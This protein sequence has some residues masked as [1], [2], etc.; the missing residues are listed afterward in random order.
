MFVRKTLKA[1]V[2]LAAYLLL[3]H[4]SIAFSQ[5]FTLE[6]ILSAPYVTNLTTAGEA[7]VLAWV[8]N[9]K[10]VRNIWVAAAPDFQPRQVT[11]YTEDDG[12]ALGSLRLTRDGRILVYVRGGSANRAGEHPNP[13]SDPDGAEQAI[14]AVRT[15]G[16]EPWRLAAGSRPL[17]SPDE[18]FV[19][20]LRKGK[21]F[22]VE[23][24]PPHG[25]TPEA[26][27]LFK[28]RGRVGHL[29]WS[30]D[31]QKLAFVSFR[32]DHNFVGIYE[33]QQHKIRWIAPGVDRDLR[34]V[35]S[36]DGRRL[37]FIR[38]PGAKKHEL[39]NIMSGNPFAIWVADAATG[40]AREIWRSPGDDGGFAQYY[41][42]EPLRWTKN[43]RILFYSEHEGWM[44]IYSMRPD[45]SD[46]QDLTPG[47]S[48]AEHSAVSPDG[49]YLYF[50]SNK[51]DIDRRHIWR[52][53]TEGG[54][55]EAVTRGQGIETDPVVLASGR[56]IAYRAAG[57]NHPP[58][59]TLAQAD[60]KKP[61]AVY[62]QQ[63]P[64]DF[65]QKELVVPQPVIFTSGDGWKI[66]AQLFL[67][68]GAKP[69]DNR[70]ALIFMHGGPI[71]QMLLGWHY[72]GYYANAYAMN[73]YMASKGYVVLSV[74]YR[75]GIG[76]GRDFRLAPN[77]GPRGASEYQDIIAAGLYLQKRPEVDPHKIGLWG[78]SYGGYLTAMGLARDSDLFAAGVDLH[79]VHD[80]AFRA[81]DFSP[82]GGWG[83]QGE[84]LLELALKSSPVAD[85][86]Y[87]TSPILLIHGDD[88]RNVLFQ[89]TTDLVQRL[90]EKGVHTEVLVFPDEVHGFLRYESWLRAYQATADFFD[91][92]LRRNQ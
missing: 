78:G 4:V 74:N 7:D 25:K 26:K 17:L 60:G 62:P 54:R 59:I 63:W 21:P 33:M 82:G 77:Q 14:W 40:T 79:G 5:S 48:E 91:R 16:G 15:D 45:G 18:Q 57:T 89:Q 92:F 61:K 34:P 55:P 47:R 86:T 90:R 42:A 3:L 70:P 80:W 51:D 52:T 65:P 38:T 8:S 87:W 30:P 22:R 81:T 10:G 68:K 58:V 73:Q 53:P 66:H 44:H 20:F 39:R 71:R 13:T 31:G 56:L 67:P 12:Q 19:V 83:L 6:A 11:Q 75:C 88:D 32:G 64:A 69:G 72:R 37:A 85:L 35:W 46:L 27:P 84:E 43:D 49:K 28:V 29:R 23:L 41:P 36:P 50:S 9:E 2:A 1:F 76:Y 24:L